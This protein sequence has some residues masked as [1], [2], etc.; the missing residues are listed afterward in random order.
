LSINI[1]QTFAIS[2]DLSKSATKEVYLHHS[3]IDKLNK[4]LLIRSDSKKLKGASSWSAYFGPSRCGMTL[5]FRKAIQG[6]NGIA[7]VSLGKKTDK[8]DMYTFMSMQL[9]RAQVA[10]SHKCMLSIN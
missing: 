6:V 3:N 2:R 4:H 1:A 8:E 10:K 9:Q 5:G 7:Y